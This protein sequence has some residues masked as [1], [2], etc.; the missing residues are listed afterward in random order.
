MVFARCHD[1]HSGPIVL[2]IIAR[3]SRSD[4]LC[5]YVDI[6]HNRLRSARIAFEVWA[7]MLDG[8]VDQELSIRRLG[9]PLTVLG[10]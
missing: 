2:S 9:R 5:V 1:V 10:K 4:R 7:M 6:G 8:E 3:G